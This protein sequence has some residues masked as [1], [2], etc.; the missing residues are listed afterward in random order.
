MKNLAKRSSVITSLVCLFG[1]GV[2]SAFG[3]TPATPGPD[4]VIL[5]HF[6]GRTPG[7]PFGEPGYVASAPGLNQAAS[8]GAGRYYSVQ[9]SYVAPISWHH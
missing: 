7:V 3:G 5:D 4:T 2:I 6:D 8:L 1:L 9:N